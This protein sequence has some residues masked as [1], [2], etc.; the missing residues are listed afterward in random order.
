MEVQHDCQKS[1]CDLIALKVGIDWADQEHVYQLRVVGAKTRVSGSVKQTPESLAEWIARLQQMIPAG[2]KIG[3]ALEQ[4]RGSLIHFLQ[5]FAF[6]VLYPINPKSLAKFRE[7]FRPSCPKDD[8]D[9]AACLLEMLEGHHHKLRPWH[10]DDSETRKLALLCELRR[11]AVDQRTGLVN[12]IVSCLKLYFPQALNWA[13]DMTSNMACHFLKKWA[14]LEAIQRSRPDTIR[15]FYQQQHCRNSKLIDQRLADIRDAVALTSDPVIIQPYALLVASYARIIL[16]LN[17]TI[18]MYQEQ[19]D[20]LFAQHPDHDLF[21]SL[22]GAGQV[23]APRLLVAMGHDRSRYE[24]ASDVQQFTGIAPITRRSGT[25]IS[26]SRRTG[27]PNFT[28]QSFLEFSQHSVGFSLWANAFYHHQRSLGKGRYAAL[29]ALAY[30]W[31]RIIFHCWKHNQL[32]DEQRYIR[33]LERANS[34][35][36]RLIKNA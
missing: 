21:A 1:G 31:I 20:L 26:V 10:P 29:R 18:D 16:E 8:P 25:L 17:D 27:K 3:I 5:Q 11:R 9:D 7:A 28:H 23:M 32:Y 36:F 12:A 13:A 19:I 30:K 34:P 4:S 15:S 22:P 35:L 24:S 6:V 14:T 33:S 2:K